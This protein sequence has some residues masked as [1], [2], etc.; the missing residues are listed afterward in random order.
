MGWKKKQASYELRETKQSIAV[1]LRWGYDSQSPRE[2]ICVQVCLR[3]KNVA[4]IQR[5]R[6]CKTC[7][8]DSRLLLRRRYRLLKPKLALTAMTFPL[9]LLLK[10]VRFLMPNHLDLPKYGVL[11]ISFNN[12][13][14]AYELYEMGRCQGKPLETIELK[15]LN[16]VLFCIS[17]RILCNYVRDSSLTCENTHGQAQ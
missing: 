16:L 2:T 1:L 8:R 17:Y 4:W 6:A 9:R 10:R 11:L 12:S 13:I 14:Q 5:C 3:F 7:E 15:L